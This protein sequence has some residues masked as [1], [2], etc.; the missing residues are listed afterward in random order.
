MQ[1]LNKA[2][3]FKHEGVT[4]KR[5]SGYHYSI[6]LKQVILSEVQQW[7]SIKF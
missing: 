2:Y 5:G 7:Q 3:N 1:Y 6:F 4:P